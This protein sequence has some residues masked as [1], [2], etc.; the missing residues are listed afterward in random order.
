[1]TSHNPRIDAAWQRAYEQAE[2]E[3]GECDDFPHEWEKRKDCARCESVERRAEQIMDE[4]AD[5]DRFKGT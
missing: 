4:W 5:A 1:M 2:D 3:L